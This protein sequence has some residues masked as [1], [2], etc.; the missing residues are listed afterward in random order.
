MKRI[1]AS[2]AFVV[3]LIAIYAL[4][5]IADDKPANDNSDNQFAQSAASAG[6][7]EVRASQLALDKGTSDDVKKFARRMVDD[8]TKANRELMDLATKKGFR[9][10]AAMTQ[11]QV[12]IFAQLARAI[13]DFDKQYVKAQ[14]DGHEEAVAL[15]EKQAKDGKDADLKGWAEKTLPTL[16]DH[17]K[18][19]RD[20]SKPGD[21]NPKNK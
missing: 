10:Q 21:E 19:V 1:L 20:L 5:A 14:L 15:F 12:D 2:V 11:K 7:F 4:T 13:Q 8:H 9:I 6:E 18:I 16:K 17:M 3:G